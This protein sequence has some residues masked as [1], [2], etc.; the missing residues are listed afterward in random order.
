[1]KITIFTSN[2]PRHMALIQN[3]ACVADE[4]IV[5]MECK[6]NFPGQIADRIP[7]TPVMETY[8]SRVL[9]AEQ[10]V[11]GALSFTL[12]NVRVLPIR[13]GDL[14]F[15]NMDILTP[16]LSSDQYVVFGSSYIKGSLSEF[17]VANRAKN[18]HMGVSPYYR[19]NS[20]NFW[21]LY[22]ARPDL[23]GATIH[24][25]SKGLDNGGML[26]HALPEVEAT[27]PFILGM[28]AV[29]A[30]HSGL[31]HYLSTGELDML[32]PI[33]QDRGQEL[34]Y[35]RAADFTDEVAR[36]YLDNHMAGADLAHALKGRDLSA[37]VRAYVG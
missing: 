22:D 21:A 30:A 31:V 9:R 25:L 19:G 4:I 10:D 35:T 6:T 2:Q 24:L 12:P 32:S 15:L 20:C 7:K 33:E 18:I 17:L 37:Y 36:A 1:M 3:L 34:R 14:N 26:F 11:F 29:R 13:A 27:D 8:F 28:K 23:V 16:A 5:V